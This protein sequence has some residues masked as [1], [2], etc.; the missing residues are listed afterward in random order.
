VTRILGRQ[1]LITTSSKRCDEGKFKRAVCVCTLQGGILALDLLIA[2]TFLEEKVGVN[3]ITAE[4]FLSGM[5][6]GGYNQHRKSALENKASD[7]IGRYGQ[8]TDV[9]A[10][11]SRA[12]GLDFLS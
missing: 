7:P 5:R 1:L 3:L 8:D 6:G 12:S 10:A 11:Q 4:V 2:T 9:G